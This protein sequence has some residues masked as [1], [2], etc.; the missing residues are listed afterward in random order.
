MTEEEK[1]VVAEQALRPAPSEQALAVQQVRLGVRE[2]RL[3]GH[4]ESL[5]TEQQPT[6]TTQPKRCQPIAMA[7]F[8]Y[9]RY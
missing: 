7:S 2:T 1:A 6:A 5:A 8:K 3:G 4:P 9:G